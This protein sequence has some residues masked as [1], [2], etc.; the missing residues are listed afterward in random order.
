M[1]LH[2][3]S[4]IAKELGNAPMEAKSIQGVGSTLIFYI[5][6]GINHQISQYN[7]E[8]L[9]TL[10][11]H[12]DPIRLPYS[13]VL[14]GVNK[15]S[16][17]IL[18]VDDNEFNRLVIGEL[19][20]QEGIE[21]DEAINGSLAVRAVESKNN[22]GDH[23]SVIIMDCQMPVMDGWEATTKILELAYIGAIRFKPAIIGYSAYCGS[24]EETKSREVGMSEF[25]IKPTPKHIFISAIKSYL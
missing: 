5:N 9:E 24:E 8:N 15:N 21:Y 7:S 25:L 18:I 2:I 12:E 16:A 17:K 13:K 11:E 3:S 4:L 6:T 10:M 14:Q 20:K 23:Y 19:L 1:K 22:N